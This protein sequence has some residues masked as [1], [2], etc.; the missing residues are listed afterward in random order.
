MN[1]L[2]QE[3]AEREQTNK[4][5]QDKETSSTSNLNGRGYKFEERAMAY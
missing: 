1:P 4:T 2:Q 3:R 5:Q